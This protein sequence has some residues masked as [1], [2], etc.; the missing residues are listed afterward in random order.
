[1]SA[2]VLRLYA[3]LEANADPFTIPPAFRVVCR[4]RDRAASRPPQTPPCGCGPA[5]DAY[6]LICSRAQPQEDQRK[7]TNGCIFTSRLVTWPPMQASV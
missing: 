6:R 3:L 7:W 4:S 1:M 5:H 2:A